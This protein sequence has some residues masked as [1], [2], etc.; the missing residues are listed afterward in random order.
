MSVFY[1]LLAE[2][3]V[4]GATAKNVSRPEK[5]QLKHLATKKLY[6]VGKKKVKKRESEMLQTCVLA[7]IFVK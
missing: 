6:L 4:K 3:I 5:L 1:R 7:D 2:V